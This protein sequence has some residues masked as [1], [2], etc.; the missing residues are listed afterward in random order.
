MI[1]NHDWTFSSDNGH[2]IIV[3][4]L[5][6]HKYIVVAA[7]VCFHN[8]FHLGTHSTRE[9]EMRGCTVWRYIIFALQIELSHI[10]AQ[11]LI[12]ACK[13]YE[14]LTVG[15]LGCGHPEPSLSS[16]ER[17]GVWCEWRIGYRLPGYRG[18]CGNVRPI[19]IP[20]TQKR[21]HMNWL[22]RTS[23]SCLVVVL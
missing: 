2:D 12:S 11:L 17:Y 8:L 22:S 9:S 18:H 14:C 15:V 19:R 13:R 21:T 1:K 5:I 16:R 7:F 20:R 23:A 10:W 4:L 6:A 3:A